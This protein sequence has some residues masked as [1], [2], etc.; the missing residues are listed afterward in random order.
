M[1]Q[2]IVLQDFAQYKRGMYVQTDAEITTILAG[3]NASKI[4]LTNQEIYFPTPPNMGDMEKSVYDPD[5]DGKVVSAVTA[6]NGLEEHPYF[7][8][9]PISLAAAELLAPYN[10]LPAEAPPMPIHETTA[11]LPAV[12]ADNGTML[13]QAGTTYHGVI[14]L[15]GKTNITVAKTGEGADPIVIPGNR[16]VGA[17]WTSLGNG[18]FS[19]PLA[20]A[21]LN[22]S[23]MSGKMLEVSHWPATKQTVLV[24]ASRSGNNQITLSAPPINADLVGAT[25]VITGSE[26]TWNE[27][28]VDSVAGAVINL[29]ATPLD[30]ADGA[31]SISVAQPKVYF[32]GKLWMLSQAGAQLQ[33]H[34]QAGTL[35]VRMDDDLTP[36]D[37]LI[38]ATAESSVVGGTNCKLIQVGLHGGVR[39]WF[40]GI[41]ANNAVYYGFAQSVLR[42]GIWVGGTADDNGA[43]N[44]TAV[45]W[46]ARW[47]GMSAIN[48]FRRYKN[49]SVYNSR[50]T[51]TRLI[52]CLITETNHN[53]PKRTW[54]AVALYNSTGGEF[55]VEIK[56]SGG[57]GI[58]LPWDCKVHRA[59]VNGAGINT[60]DV[61]GIYCIGRFGVTQFD[62]KTH[63]TY[64]K[65]SNMLGVN[66]FGFYADDYAKNITIDRLDVSNV[67]HGT[68]IHSGWNTVFG[69]V[70]FE[71]V[72]E[73]VI[74]VS[75]NNAAVRAPLTY[76]TDNNQFRHVR[77]RLLAG[78]KLFDLRNNSIAG[79]PFINMVTSERGSIGGL[80]QAS[81]S[82]AITGGSTTY[83]VFSWR[84][85]FAKDSETVTDYIVPLR[86]FTGVSDPSGFSKGQ[87]IPFEI[88]LSGSVPAGSTLQIAVSNVTNAA[89]AY[90]LVAE[91]AYDTGQGL[92]A[93]SAL[94]VGAPAVYT[95]VPLIFGTLKV[96]IRF[97][98]LV[99]PGNTA[100]SIGFA[101]LNGVGT[102]GSS[103]GG[104]AVFV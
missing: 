100:A 23:M 19:T 8:P 29:N 25:A 32:E 65:V 83:D 3:A 81:T 40:A 49:A 60:G 67:R 69:E 88:G 75:D 16:V 27:R 33:W 39:G 89:T 59:I 42:D 37:R 96:S 54:G 79:R 24:S 70:N 72:I 31:A 95:T 14:D 28:L 55:D 93:Y 58:F 15:T 6:D 85:V 73:S 2:A 92:G 51:N 77:G 46:R 22:V 64:A 91:V 11:A 48:G 63:I 71:N 97:Q 7:S 68:L 13:L 62:N 56:N 18:V 47:C 35:Y 36:G 99:A 4:L 101:V 50:T 30:P 104:T 52:D 53:M 94:T 26:F 10:G 102:T 21:P 103:G 76:N 86:G 66:H 61:G 57:T 45:K 44:F 1:R 9:S 87:K 78:T 41:G 12:P 90:S 34:H 84:Q 5:G 74:V 80:N 43:T 82:F 17:V 20:I 38:I 98:T